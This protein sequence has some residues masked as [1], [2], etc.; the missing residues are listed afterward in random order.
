MTWDFLYRGETRDLD[1]TTRAGVV[2][3]FVRLSDGCTHYEMAGP[4]HAR[5]VVLVHGFS[6]PCFVWDETFAALCSAGCRVLRYDLFGRGYSDRPLVS[7]D[8]QLFVRQLSQLV[9]ELKIDACDVIGLSMGGAVAAAFAVELSERVKRLV[10]IDPIGVDR[11][12]LGLFYRAALVPGI[13]ELALG[14][15]GTEKMVQNLASDFFDASEI[16]R[17]RERYRVQMQFRGFKRAII[18]TLRGNSLN[19]F[20]DVYRRLGKLQMPVL[21]IWGRQDR[22]LPVEQSASILQMVPRA[23]FEIIEN[24]GHI[25]NCEQPAVVHPLLIDFLQP[26]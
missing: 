15:L 22:T 20:P 2:G 17:F 6:V 16:E 7:Y 19:G 14:L 4:A 13:S 25:P 10:L 8:L 11:M 21:L 5:T 26:T 9:D 24:C 18:S 1:D 23:R 12:P 3:S